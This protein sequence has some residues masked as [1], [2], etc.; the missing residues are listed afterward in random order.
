MFRA[1]LPF[2]QPIFWLSAVR[3]LLRLRATISSLEE[4]PGDTLWR[5]VDFHRSGRRGQSQKLAFIKE[6]LRRGALSNSYPW[7]LD[8]QYIATS[9]SSIRFEVLASVEDQVWVSSDEEEEQQEDRSERVV[10]AKGAPPVLQAKGSV[11]RQLT[12]RTQEPKAH[13]FSVAPKQPLFPPPGRFESSESVGILSVEQQGESSAG[14]SS[15]FQASEPK[16]VAGSKVSLHPPVAKAA[17]PAKAEGPSSSS[18]EAAGSAK[19]LRLPRSRPELLSGSSKVPEPKLPPQQP[20]RP[21][22]L[23]PDTAELYVWN[24][25]GN[26]V[27]APTKGFRGTAGIYT[28][29]PAGEK[30]LLA[31]DWYQTLSRS[32]TQSAEGVGRVP[33]ENVELLKRL[34]DRYQNRLVVVV[35][36]FISGSE[37]NLHNLIQAC[38]QTP[39]LSSLISYVFI[40]RSKTGDQGKLRTLEAVCQRLTPTCL[41]DDNADIVTEASESVFTI[42]LKLRRKP[43]ARRADRVFNFLE[44]CQKEIEGEIE[45]KVPNWNENKEDVGVR[46]QDR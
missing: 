12:L 9:R 11:A 20:L 27:K 24:P 28:E 34:K 37:K 45:A 44:D 15:S 41:V 31:L 30:F 17:P 4:E 35:C 29:Y 3:L 36:S 10:K 2:H 21:I 33:D 19:R 39:G 46:V 23:L 14:S 22:V 26:L 40:T 5:A 25:S 16:G 13:S 1:V 7:I 43:E 42:H 32:R 8:E 6:G 18:A 38:E